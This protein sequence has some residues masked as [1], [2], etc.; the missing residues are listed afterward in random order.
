MTIETWLLFVLVS[1]LPAISPGPGVLLAISNA[2]RFGT[3]AALLSG[4]GNAIGLTILGYAVTLGLGAVMATSAV[5]FT[6]VKMIG[7]IYLLYLGIRVLRDK[8]AFRV[9]ET[10]TVAKR[11][12]KQLFGTAILVSLTNP[13]AMLLIG[14]LFPQFVGSNAN[15]LL[16]ISILS[17]T[18]AILCFLNHVFLAVF[19]GRVRNYL[20]SE[21][22]TRRLRHALGT[23]F[24][25]F[26]A[27]LASYS[28]NDP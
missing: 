6:I 7:A 15:D 23:T 3:K 16:S 25:G 2:L 21:R 22:I 1:I 11:S 24:I 14:A 26:G 19:G 13:K 12:G 9:D 18:Y 5:M 27:A 17:F 28:R 10:V 8:T 4:L 20:K